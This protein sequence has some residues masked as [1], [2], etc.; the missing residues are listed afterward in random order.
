MKW[1]Y[2][3]VIPWVLVL[4]PIDVSAHHN[5][6]LNITSTDGLINIQSTRGDTTGGLSIALTDLGD[7][8]VSEV[9]VGNGLGYEP[10]VTVL[11][12]DGSEIGS[13]LAYAPTLG[14][15]INVITCDLTG[16]GYDEIIVSPQRGGGPHIRIF[17]RYGTQIDDGGFFAYHESFRDGVNLACGDLINDAREELVTLPAAGGGPHVRVW[18]WGHK[19][20][21]VEN[22]FA[23]HASNRSGLVG[24]IFEKKLFLAE[25]HTSTPTIKTFVIH[26]TRDVVNEKIFPISAL[27]VQSIAMF[28][29]QLLLSTTDGT[30]YNTDTNTIFV[31]TEIQNAT[32]AT[33]NKQLIVSNGRQLFDA[34]TT[35]KR[36]IV[37]I[38]EQRLFAYEHG[39]LRNSFLI[40]S[41]LNNATPL[42]KH[43]ILAKVPEVHYA[44]F[45]GSGSPDNYDLGWIPYNLRFYPHIYV[46]Y[47]PWHN[48]FG[49]KMSHGCVNVNLEN[50]MW[51][52]EWSEEGIEIEVREQ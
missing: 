6:T 40:S 34:N 23:F 29:D 14:V 51:I 26:N 24:T 1:L 16:D 3:F 44:W 7:D 17:N 18:S 48:N 33:D 38:D 11:R 22:F 45:Y 13:F 49:H 30:I 39:V 52:Y 28:D 42:G 4:S 15:G 8:G 32:I 20:E 12:R 31:S 9:I 35:D 50:M 19:A 27:G 41:G 46:H 37:D 47:A 2:L 10:R 25:Q 5:N 43:T 21:L 36:I